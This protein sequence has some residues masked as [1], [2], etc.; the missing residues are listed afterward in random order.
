MEFILCYCQIEMEDTVDILDY[1]GQKHGNVSV[2]LRPCL[3]NGTLPSEEQD[4]FVDD[5]KELVSL[6]LNS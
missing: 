6:F 5:P 4:P 1:K 2:E 3:P